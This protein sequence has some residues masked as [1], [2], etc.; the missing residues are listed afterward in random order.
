MAVGVGR[1]HHRSVRVNAKPARHFD[2]AAVEE[3]LRT[4]LPADYEEW[5]EVFGSG[6]FETGVVS[7]G[8]Q[9]R[10]STGRGSTAVLWVLGEDRDQL[11]VDVVRGHLFGGQ[12]ERAAFGRRPLSRR[13]D[14]RH[15]R[16]GGRLKAPALMA[17]R[18]TP[19]CPA[20]A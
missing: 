10:L 15:P 3:Q 13:D 7:G 1:P 6:Q 5:A 12:V 8:G 18:P 9:N 20:S 11:A 14:A 17:A 16:R 19:Q 2:W 4:R